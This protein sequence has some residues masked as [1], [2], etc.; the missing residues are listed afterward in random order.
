MGA[1]RNMESSSQEKVLHPNS[2]LQ[3]NASAKESM[4]STGGGSASSS[5]MRK[6]DK[7]ST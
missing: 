5:M 2:R 3:A 7:P 6:V 1:K 4:R